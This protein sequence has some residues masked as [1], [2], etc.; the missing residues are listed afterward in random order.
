MAITTA[1]LLTVPE[2]ELDELELLEALDE[3]LLDELELLLESLEAG[4]PP[5]EARTNTS[6]VM[7]RL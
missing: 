1:P 2:L 5:Q 7:A 6:V 3:E 4:E